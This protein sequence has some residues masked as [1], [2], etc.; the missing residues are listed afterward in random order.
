MVSANGVQ[1]VRSRIPSYLLQRSHTLLHKR[2][3]GRRVNST[4]LDRGL[5]GLSRLIK[6]TYVQWDLSTR[7]GLFQG[8]DARLK[9]LF[10]L[11]F[12]VAIS[13]EK[14]P[15]SELFIAP[16][17]F[18]LAI[19]SRLRLIPL[20]SRVLGLS[21]VFGVL[22]SFPSCCNILVP[23]TVV[24]PLY[25][26]DRTYDL[27]FFHIPRTV[28]LTREGMTLAA[29][30]SLR[31]ANSLTVS[32][33]VLFTTPFPDLVKALRLLRAPNVIIVILTLFY[34][35]LFILTCSLEEM[36]LAMKS[37]LVSAVP[38]QEART[39]AADRMASVYRKSQRTCDEVFRAMQSRGFTGEIR[40]TDTHRLSSKDWLAGS[41]LLAVWVLIVLY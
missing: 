34:K 39:W 29:L 35:Y 11:F 8:L 4:F 32:L 1:A 12:A 23:G 19:L 5:L 38:G 18:V 10:L 13:L 25:S 27:L 21:F 15:V 30:L 24:A 28:G 37:R 36:H 17:L 14:D 26:F 6:S 41:A 33:L 9:L 40:L 2:Q 20:Y 16:I 7:E 3:G 22:L 31:V